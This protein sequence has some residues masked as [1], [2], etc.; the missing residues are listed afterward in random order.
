MK[1]KQVARLGRGAREA[2]PASWRRVIHPLLVTRIAATILMLPSTVGADGEVPLNPPLV[3]RLDAITAQQVEAHLALVYRSQNPAGLYASSDETGALLA[4]P[5]FA[6]MAFDAFATTRNTAMLAQSANSVGRYYSYLYASADRDGD[7]LV[8][9]PAKIQ[10]RETRIEDPAF[11]S[12]LAVD[13][14]NLARANLELRRTMQ[15][16]FW[17]DAARSA[18][19]AVVANTFDATGDFCFARDPGTGQFIRRVAPAAALPVDFSLVMGS[20][21]AERVRA[22]VVTWSSQAVVNV[23]PADRAVNAIDFMT[24]VSVLSD[25]RHAPVVDG[26]RRSI[27]LPSATVNPV[28]RYALARSRVDV[29]L[30]SDD[31]AFGIMLNLQRGAGFADAERFRIEQAIPKV[32]VLA[33]APGAPPMSVQ[34]ADGAIRTVFTTVAALR[35][36]LRTSSFFKPEDRKVFPG[37]DPNVAAQ[38]MLDDVTMLTHRAENRLF[39]MRY[40]ASGSRLNVTLPEERVVAEDPFR[41]HWETVATKSSA[42]WKT[43]SVGIYGDALVPVKG[44]PFSVTPSSPLRFATRHLARGTTGTLRL[45]TFTAVFESPSGTLSRYHA[46]RSVYLGTPVGISARFPQGRTMS[47]STVPVDVVLKGNALKT[48]VA[49]YFWFSPAGLRLT[50]GNQGL[51]RMG[52]GDSTVVRLN[53]EV[54]APCRPGVFPFT[55]KFLA[56]ERDAGTINSSLFKPYQWTF[57]GPFPSDGGLDKPHPPERGVNLLSTYPGPNGAARWRQVPAS[58]CDPRGGIS[59]RALASDRGVQYLYTIVACAYETDLQAR[60][61]SN[62]P[63]ALYVNGRPALAVTSAKGDSAKANIHLDP[64][65]NHILIKVIGDADARVSFV[66]GNDLAELAQ[67]YRELTA[68]ELAQGSAPSE[69]RRLVTLRFQDPEALSVAVVGSFNGWSP[70]TNPMQ[71]KGDTWELT[72][73]LLPGK[74]AYRFLV[75]QKKQVLDPASKGTEPDG[76]GGKNSVLV[77]NK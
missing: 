35:E 19:R 77:V 5:L 67:G 24:A 6:T 34:E 58:A 55:L 40:A 50:G 71:K 42:Q 72:L 52:T 44:S 49:K 51:I 53:V 65:K 26:L 32:R 69:S 43:I 36:R 47:A 13:A 21:Y 37:A 74:Y 48:N 46:T 15:A 54:P 18:E 30:S 20:N 66:L 38:R 28:E 70:A 68:R 11:N 60:L 33:L 3:S 22:Q 10:G 14:R 8:E 29:P 17:Y 76:Y 56:G 12:L 41:V 73:S 4:R 2:V 63:A 16:L 61:W 59:L 62:A 23:V 45:F 1:F 64:D 27:P 25:G 7:R 39:E 57:V 31:V 9:T 75:D